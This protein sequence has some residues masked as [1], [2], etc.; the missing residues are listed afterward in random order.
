MIK[1]IWHFITH[2]EA[3][4]KF[5]E[6]KW[7][8]FS[9]APLR[10]ID[11]RFKSSVVP[12]YVSSESKRTK[13]KPRLY[14]SRFDR[15]FSFSYSSVPSNFVTSWGDGSLRIIT[16]CK[17]EVKRNKSAFRKFTSWSCL[18]ASLK[19]NL[20]QLFWFFTQN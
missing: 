15:L 13:L 11:H 16:S 4:K 2:F 7:P 5:L 1:Q 9:C 8:S 12:S 18:G 20:R 6:W 3:L 17:K 10:S 14:Q 19:K